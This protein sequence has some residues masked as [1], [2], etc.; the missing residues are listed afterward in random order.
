MDAGA[1]LHLPYRLPTLRISP[2]VWPEHERLGGP[3]GGGRGGRGGAEYTYNAKDAQ[4][5]G[6]ISTKLGDVYAD[7]F[8]Q[9][10]LGGDKKDENKSEE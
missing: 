5:G 4:Q 2:A 8:A 1:G 6:K 7:L 3:R 10:G 9:F